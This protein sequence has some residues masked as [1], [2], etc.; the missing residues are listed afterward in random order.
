MCMIS[1]GDARF[2]VTAGE[3]KKHDF[4][5]S[6]PNTQL[7]ISNARG[8]KIIIENLATLSKFARRKR[9][10]RRFDSLW[11]VPHITE[12]LIIRSDRNGTLTL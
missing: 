8:E 11:I 3:K 7:V 5:F 6:N 12:T 2:S 4:F 10:E 9:T 1:C